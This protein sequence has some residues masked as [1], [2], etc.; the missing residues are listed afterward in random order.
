MA[1]INVPVKL[2]IQNLQSLVT[3]LQNKLGNLKVGSTGFKAIQNT[4]SAIRGE[5]DK[6]SIQTAKPFIDAGQFTRAEHSVEKLEDEIEKVSLV[7]SRLKFSDLELTS[8]Q[9]AD[10]KAFEDQ[11]TSIRDKLKTVK[12]TAKDEFLKSAMGQEW[13]KIDDTAFS[14]SLS[15]ITNNIRKAV[16]DQNAELGKLEQ[17]ALDYQRA[18]TENQRIQEFVKKTNGDPL[19]QANL[20][21][22]Y[23]QIF[24]TTQKGQ[25]RY[26]NNGR[27]LL[28]DW[29]E[30]QLHLDQSTIAQII[31]KNVSAANVGAKLKEV[32]NNQMQQNQHIVDNNPNIT[33][34]VDAARDKYNELIAILRQVG[35]SEQQVAATEQVLRAALTSTTHDLNDYKEKLTQIAQ[36]NAGVQNTTNAMKSQLESLRTTL[37]STNSEFIRMQR[38]QQ[39]FNQ[40]KMAVVNFMGFNQVLNLTKNAIRNAINHI[41]ELDSVMN[42]ISIVTDMST[43]DLWNQVDAYSAMA[44][45]YG[46]SIKGAYEVSQIYYQQGLETKDV[47]TLTN[48]TLKLAKISGLDYAQTTDYMTTALRGFKME[49]SDAATVVDVYSNL[50]AHTAVSQ[51][52]LAVAM[53]KTASSLQNVGTTF[54]EASAMIS[55][56]VA[57]TRE[58]ATNIGSAMKSIAS[59]YGELTKDPT[60]LVD[61]EGEAL[62]FNK[63]DAAL[64]SVGISMKTVDGQFREFTDVIV[65]LGEKWDQ[66][67][68]TQQRYIATQFAGNRQQSRF[69]ALVSNIDLLK[70]NMGY[71]EESE[72]TG[73]IQALK[74]LDSIEAK[75]EQVRVAYQQFY[76][77]IGAESVW[78]GFL[79]GAKN[80]INTLNGM[81]KLFGKIPIAAINAIGS[82]VTLVKSLGVT[83]LSGIAKVFGEG[84]AKGITT[85]IPNAKNATEEVVQA[86]V[87]TAKG[88]ANDVQNAGQ[89]LSAALNDGFNARYLKRG[90]GKFSDTAAVSN[91]VERVS[92]INNLS[93]EAQSKA[94]NELAKDMNNAGV[95][96]SQ[97]FNT[98]KAGGQ[99]A[100]DIVERLRV[101]I[102]GEGN[103]A[104]DA[105]G[106]V[107]S[108]ASSHQKTLS[109]VMAF[110]SALNILATAIDTTSR[111]GKALSGTFM[112]IGGTITAVAGI[113]KAAAAETNAIPWVA[114]AS[115]IISVISGITSIIKSN[116][117]EAKLEEF[118]AKAEELSNTAK[119]LKADYRTLDSGISKLKELENARYDSAE[120][121]E[122]YQQAVDK[123]AEAYPQLI[124]SYTINGE[125]VLNANEMEQ[126]LT[127]ARDE[128][129][130][131]TLRAA[132]AE[133]EKAKV[134]KEADKKAIYTS[135]DKFDDYL[136]GPESGTGWALRYQGKQANTRENQDVTGLL[137][138]INDAVESFDLD[139]IISANDALDKY[140]AEHQ[141]QLST[142]LNTERNKILNAVS[143]YRGD[144]SII[145]ATNRA[146]V[147]A[148][149]NKKYG[150]SNTSSVLKDNSYLLNLATSAVFNS[151]NSTPDKNFTS[152]NIDNEADK[153]LGNL[154]ES[155]GNL[156]D[157]QI[158]QLN[159]VLE[160]PEHYSSK[161]LQTLAEQYGI[162]I[163]QWLID[164]FNDK[165]ETNYKSLDTKLNVM[166]K[167]GALTT[168]DEFAVR[169]ALDRENTTL[170][171]RNLM[172]AG[173]NQ[174]Q[175]LQKNGLQSET[176]LDDFLDIYQSIIQVPA[177]AR[178]N[179]IKAFIENGFTKEGLEKTLAYI[180]DNEIEGV[181]TDA[182]GR[183]IENVIPNF[184]LA[185]DTA[186]TN[187]TDTVDKLEQVTSSIQSGVKGSKL[188]KTISEAKQLGLEFKREDFEQNGNQFIIKYERLQEELE[189][190]DEKLHESVGDQ[191]SLE[192]YYTEA[193]E[194]PLTNIDSVRAI[195]G[196]QFEEFYELTDI[197]D[198]NGNK[199]G[200]REW[201]KRADIE[202]FDDA[203]EEAYEAAKL[204]LENYELYL[205]D[206]QAELLQTS[207]WKHGDYSSL[208]TLGLDQDLFGETA[209][210]AFERIQTLANDPNTFT[211]EELGQ[212]NVLNAVEMY[213][214]GLATL[215][216]DISKHD[217]DYILSRAAQYEGLPE[218]FVTE[219]AQKIASGEL[220]TIAA[221]K[222]YAAS[223]GNTIEETN[224]LIVQAITKNNKIGIQKDIAGLI[225]G[226]KFT[227]DDLRSTIEKYKTGE[228]L[229]I[230]KYIDDNGQIIDKNLASIYELDEATGTYKQVTGIALEQV[231]NAW[232]SF[233][234]IEI[235]K[236]SE[237]YKE[238]VSQWVTDTINT[239]D[240]QDIGTQMSN[241][242]SNLSSAKI[243]TRISLADS[244][245][246]EQQLETI[247]GQQLDGYYEVVSEWER[248]NL[249]LALTASNTEVK[250]VLK[251]LQDSIKSKRN[252]NKALSGII[253]QNIS[254]EDYISYLQNV[255]G[256]TNADLWNDGSL[257]SEAEKQGYIWDEYT[258]TYRATTDAIDAINED[259]QNAIDNN[260]SEETIAEL[261][262]QAADLEQTLTHDKKR[263]ALSTLISNYKDVETS[264]SEFYAQFG[265][266]FSEAELRQKGVLT[267]DK[268]GKDVID[269]NKLDELIEGYDDLFKTAFDSLVDEYITNAQKAGSL[270]TQGTTNMTEMSAFQEAYQQ[271]TGASIKFIYDPILQ[272][273]T[274]DAIYLRN[275]LEAAAKKTGLDDVGQKQWIED[276]IKTLTVDNLDFSSILSGNASVKEKSA[277]TKQLETYIKTHLSNEYSL[278]P[279]EDQ[280]EFLESYTKNVFTNLG[281][282]GQ[283]AIEQL[284]SIKGELTAEEV[285]S[286]YRAQIQP[287]RDLVDSINEIGINSIVSTNQIETLN[288]IAGFEVNA[289]GVVI[290]TGRLVDA[291]K[292]IYDEMKATNEATISELNSTLGQYLDQRDGQQA[293]IDALG[294][295]TGMTYSELAE[296]YTQAGIELTEEMVD[297][298]LSEES[299][300]LK[301]LGGNQVMIADFKKFAS[302]MGWEEGS[303]AYIKAFKAYNEGL[304]GL[305][306]EAEKSIV[307]AI[308]SVSDAKVGDKLNFT[309]L[310]SKLEYGL[311]TIIEWE[312]AKLENG[313]L[314]IEDGINLPSVI[315]DLINLAADNAN[316]LPQ[317]LEELN[318]VIEDLLSNMV[319]SISSGL[320][321]NLGKKEAKELANWAKQQY[322]LDLDISR[323]KKGFKLSQ[324]SAKE[325]YETLKDIDSISAQIVLDEL[326]ESIDESITG[327]KELKGVMKDVAEIRATTESDDFKFMDNKIPSGQNNPIN[328][329][330]NWSE[331]FKK[332]NEAG[333]AS[334]KMKNKMDYS[335]FYNIITEMGNLA[336]QTG[337]IKLSGDTVLHNMED[338]AALIEKGAA[339]LSIAAD[340]SIKVDLSKLGI[341]FSTGAKDL[342]ANVG[343]GIQE[344]AK[345]Q[346]EMLDSMIQLLE[347]IVAMEDLGNIDV[348]N[349]NTI[350]ISDIFPK[351]EYDKNGNLVEFE[352]NQAYEDWRQN[353]L[354]QITETINGEKN[355]DYNEDLAKAAKNLKI[356]GI[357]FETILGWS[358]EQLAQQGQEFL[359]KY[360]AVMDA[361]W[362]AAKSGNYNLDNLIPSIKEVLAGTGYTG[363][364]ELGDTTLAIKNGVVLEKVDGKYKTSK[365][366][367]YTD[368]D[369]AVQAEVLEGLEGVTDIEVKAD[370]QL[371][372]KLIIDTVQFDVTVDDKGQE[373]YT[374]NGETFTSQYQASQYA[375]QQ[376]VDDKMQ[377][378]STYE[379]YAEWSVRVH[380]RFVA[381][382]VEIENQAEFQSRT[383]QQVQELADAMSNGT[384]QQIVD[385]AAKIGVKVELTN[386]GLTEEQRKKL[387]EITGIEDKTVSVKVNGDTAKKDA[388]DI[389]TVL[390]QID[391]TDPK[392]DVN[393]NE[394]VSATKTAL[395]GIT[396]ELA[397]IAA[398]KSQTISITKNE[399]LNRYTNNQTTPAKM[400]TGNVGLAKAQGT[401]MG[402]L[403]PELI[404][405]NGRYFVAGQNGP[406]FVDLA[407]DAIVF[408]HLQTEQLLKHGMSSTRGQAVTNERNAVAFASGNVNGGPAMASARAA[409][410]A[411][412]QLRAQWQAIANMSAQDFAGLGGS[413]G[414]GGGGNKDDPA[415]KAWIEAV[416][417]WYNLMQEIAK[418][419]KEITHEEA[420]RTK[421]SSDW[422][423]NGAAYYESQK[424]SLQSIE[425]Q[426][427]AQEQLNISKKD[428][429]NQRRNQ[430]NEYGA[431]K[432]WYTFDEQGQLKYNEGAYDFLSDLVSRDANNVPKY[433]LEEQYNIL[434]AQGYG[435]QMRYTSSGEEIKRAEEKEGETTD[436][437]DF[438]SK[439]IQ[440]VWDQVE[441]E[442][443]EMQ[444]L[445]DTI[446][447]G[448]NKM[449]E[450]ANDRNEILAEIR[451]NQMDLEND[452]LQ[453]IVNQRQQAIDELENQRKALEDSTNKYIQGLTDALQKER[454]MYDNQQDEAEL[455]KMRRQLAILQRSG[456]GASQ[457]NNLQDQIRSREQE[458]YFNLQQQQIDKIQEAS[459]LEIERLDTQIELMTA[460]LDYE[461]ENGLLWT[462]VYDYMTNYSA[463]EIAD[464]IYQHNL[465]MWGASPLA[466]QK[467]IQEE[468]FK[469]QQW[470]A[471]QKDSKDTYQKY[472][473][474]AEHEGETIQDA[475]YGG[476]KQ[477]SWNVFNTA[478]SKLYGDQWRAISSTLKTSFFENFSKTGDITQATTSLTSS[479][480][481][482]GSQLASAVGGAFSALKAQTS[483]SSGS[484]G[485]SSGSTGGSNNNNNN[486]NNNKGSSGPSHWKVN[487]IQP[488]GT[489][490]NLGPYSSKEAAERILTQ[491]SHNG[492][493]NLSISSYDRGGIVDEDKLALVHAKESVLTANQTKILREDILSNKPTSLMNL[494]L[495]F[496]NAY[497]GIGSGYSAITND[498]GII[499]ENATVEMHIDQISNDY[500][501]RRA[502]EQAL[503]EMMRIAR[504]TSA[505]N[506]IGR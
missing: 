154:A 376:Y 134:Q 496:K 185:I 199:T 175:S 289:D 331:A 410:A 119:Q 275:Y 40:M 247:L 217:S 68:S 478:M 235:K 457:I 79:D 403:G 12:N 145:E 295:A 241:I 85:G 188:E 283:T 93:P 279:E 102:L 148:A 240:K 255:K 178:N 207:A 456:A 310:A 306:R 34:Q 286:A 273:W 325:L 412:K 179:L 364:I 362:K 225:S 84:L 303:E 416:E 268:N 156:T 487:G 125:A 414:G 467:Y 252:K 197:L 307:A 453:A 19:S 110:G 117:V 231:I 222:E 10:I 437:S 368:I 108:W 13:L 506:S 465:D 39:S 167:A 130:A 272:A 355:K 327:A 294:K 91:W 313:I 447:E 321:G 444:D 462:Q 443:T 356:D 432:D 469:A 89:I 264:L 140:L 71:A 418:L 297:S 458:Q 144:D 201:I 162:T 483:S 142:E 442:K 196:G 189:K 244:P 169:F 55:T 278:W 24:M 293:A 237:L 373:H 23:D 388:E 495:D 54:E 155:F 38:T 153:L 484:G 181:N 346:I 234:G 459:D 92:A 233:F 48:E 470:E 358:P 500:D 2:Q 50:A 285:E 213:Q 479:L 387:S 339:A 17:A 486:N 498:S 377:N 315:Q 300:I 370:K 359:G 488:S 298:M 112:A 449:L 276:Q 229:D 206:L 87:D 311:D 309:D 257:N 248:D 126:A 27:N 150:T 183:L 56:M 343:E 227:A 301:H 105:K 152:Y 312:G 253:N 299:G 400:A 419:E 474:N 160:S 232:E 430:L 170:D 424:K 435:A 29:L 211:S 58:S 490:G 503:S 30:Q 433:S 41:K 21:N 302:S 80:V 504:K 46:T 366:T 402:E 261:R 243:G 415:R 434:L 8:E 64:Q 330:N 72:D 326:N 332:M 242:I 320:N 492:W 392:I 381:G 166:T 22:L 445:Y 76:T 438:Y 464:F 351:L 372:G 88:K 74:A 143:T 146:T 129:A 176:F 324:E 360:T 173:L 393:T 429:F 454:E 353:V 481:S 47:L 493:T 66:L 82:I 128:A 405:S 397:K 45:R 450:L 277:L 367:E 141:L 460:T 408:N 15:Q 471:F 258:Q 36:N 115:G 33:A 53:S 448:E 502:G 365:G 182:F 476:D 284:K 132:E 60:K 212:P 427:I 120:A 224:T 383:H 95:L 187:I 329:L 473:E 151:I 99:D 14:K 205:K 439:S 390:K 239:E 489:P 90:A 107:S 314:S 7:M 271:L 133:A 5:I 104:E 344:V 463:T 249:L 218:T 106:K 337:E 103:A 485:G 159:T 420:L 292:A 86:I 385:A 263:D 423:K 171:E 267:T 394:T 340:G 441:A 127:T 9:K 192:Q 251:P 274:Y 123:L 316:L 52:E 425:Q 379:T 290:S 250:A 25:F 374:A 164:V 121:A 221:I 304:I 136:G 57:V 497:N 100:I 69:L 335:D 65:E 291:Y 177:V 43:A 32:L 319:S 180:N 161:D 135:N 49:M 81:P 466:T 468:L 338:A 266:G 361:F 73:T 138:A 396:S 63:V 411:L 501:A 347:T 238:I 20:G 475:V 78:K 357:S 413:G 113:I 42:K 6:L 158:E 219:V 208:T 254:R 190:L 157:N 455:L 116:S 62:A 349:D 323:T 202:G 83:L 203:L 328:Y 494:L 26:T 230:T 431:F 147:S 318:Q 378:Y 363:E 270:I 124:E 16:A 354:H 118:T 195:L 172:N 452:V 404:V 236:G 186:L 184:S 436:Q 18:L 94:W 215:L 98:V 341:D 265:A 245:E 209:E 51:E 226:Q 256:K 505:K 77:T 11:L 499:I 131:A 352:I 369:L 391:D 317:E 109:N 350:E 446:A 417:R 204:K 282:G 280:K 165:T 194:N 97:G 491:A 348:D 384:D 168:R 75:T 44:Q 3:E 296:I 1:E 28:A 139:K 4:I 96:T 163:D 223:V 386:G 461:R 395:E 210:T 114:I 382:E 122:E 191:E 281:K 31:N 389:L 228:D 200:R 472:I 440:A 220:T 288:K 334:G 406:E 37:A 480:S 399:T 375:Y 371:H 198:E 428:Y 101:A 308:K 262:K 426:M 342:K 269:L 260:A 137:L 407:S 59:R 380:G 345:S 246:L 216:D 61:E 398:M 333:K 35:V 451:D 422:Q 111:E 477:Y 482:L 259:I 67:E 214:K 409:L 287:L 174:V 193:K 421:L 149:I 336:Q 305:D 401:L 322:D 70:A